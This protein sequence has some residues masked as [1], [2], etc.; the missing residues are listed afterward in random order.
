MMKAGFMDARMVGIT[1]AGVA[2]L[3]FL[4]N[5]SAFFPMKYP[6]GEWDAQPVIGAED[7]WVRPGLHAWWKSAPQPRCVTLF[8]HGN[9]G[10]VTHRA[11]TMVAIT[12]AGAAV[13]MLDYR[14][15]G[16]SRGWP[17]ERGLY[18]DAEAAYRYLLSKGWAASQIILHG[19]SLG[20]AVA[21]DLASRV[22]CAGVI[23]EAP[24][25]SAR[26]V[27]GRVLPVLGPLL[28]WGFDAKSRIGRVR[29]PL[30]VLHGDRDE[31]I[32]FALGRELY[33]A[34]PG[35]KQH[36]TIAGA[37]HNNIL[38]TAGAAYRDRL[39]K[40]MMDACNVAVSSKSP[41]P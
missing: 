32:D 3:V 37:G 18:E 24:F 14:G 5:R 19:E 15:Y 36:W 12:E 9:A 1:A 25:P 34:A 21:V 40:F 27:A 10:N 41:R 17:T 31:V 22:E 29:A 30:L 2:L 4:A 33:D 39:R 6:H 11:D 23:L 20:T 8:L 13:L 28:V 16:R 26:A 7:D 35:P 38:H